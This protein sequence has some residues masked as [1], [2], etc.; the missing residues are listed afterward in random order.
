M[1]SQDTRHSSSARRRLVSAK[2]DLGAHMASELGLGSSDAALSLESTDIPAPTE[3]A[4]REDV[5]PVVSPIYDRT[6]LGKRFQ[7]RLTRM[8]DYVRHM[9]IEQWL[10]IAVLLLATV[11]RFWNLGAKPLHHDESEHAYFSLM[12]ARYPPGYMYDPLLHGPFQFHAEGIVFRLIMMAESLFGVGGPSGHPWINDATARILPAVFGIGIVALPLGLRRDLG[13]IGALIAA[14]LLAVSPAFVYFSRFL[15]EDIYFNFFMFAMVVCAVQYAHKR[16]IRWMVGLFVA[17]VFA[18]ATFEGIYLTLLVFLSFLA[19]LV[20]WELAHNIACRLPRELS[21]RERLFFSRAGLLLV[22][23]GLGGVL[24][25]FGL[26]LL[27]SLSTY[28][29]AHTSRT[30]VQVVQL[31]NNTVVVLLYLS[32][33]VA[34]VVIGVLLW[35][36]SRDDTQA[37][38]AD[39]FD[40]SDDEDFEPAPRSTLTAILTAPGERIAALRERIDPDE[41]PFLHMLLSISWVHWFVGCVAGWILFAAL[42][43]VLPP[44][45]TGNLTWGQGFQLGIGRGVWQGLYYWIQQQQVARGG[46][47]V[48]YYMLLLPLYEQ[49]AVVFGLAGAVYSIFRPSYFR[50]F[51][52]WWFLVSIVLYSWAGE[53]MPWLSIH[54]LLPLML[55]AALM[56]TRVIR[57]CVEVAWNVREQGFR[58]L[59]LHPAGAAQLA[60][61]RAAADETENESSMSASDNSPYAATVQRVYRAIAW[62]SVGTIVAAAL[63]L[64]LFIPMVH[65]MVE[66]AYIHPADGPHEMMVYVQTTTDVTSAMAKIEAADKKLHGGNHQLEIWVGQGEE[67]PMY[68]YLRDYYLDAH[69]GMYVSVDPNLTQKFAQGA[70]VPDVLF[71]LPSDAQAFM[72]AHPGYHARE[73]KLRSWWDEAYKPL[74]CVPSKAVKCSNA[75]NWGS[76]VGLG[77]Y[78]SYGS[79]PPPNATFNLGRA[80]SRLWNWLWYRQPLGDVNGSYDFTLVVRDGLPMQP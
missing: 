37:R 74:P 54:I 23:G 44:G 7:F 16:T 35:Q 52:V 40:D 53:K 38:N 18:Y 55:L 65:S 67:W 56:I 76:G 32:I 26:H 64:A 24:A 49:L 20:L 75:A 1:D 45:P 36:I 72:A 66:L 62:R 12:F 63:A 9:S 28:I 68:W 25:Y 71:L 51:L 43:W 59:A 79:N 6:P 17:A 60:T 50:M 10:W 19:I 3:E 21:Q 11:L 29:A 73:Y 4:A 31:E 47:P 14:L 8:W 78:L 27:N 39:M 33:I 58:A 2:R 15:R 13:R 69:P 42:Y 48:Y 5:L 46:Q 61:T 22:A 70:T 30:D 41:K 77:N 80:T 57:A 34:I